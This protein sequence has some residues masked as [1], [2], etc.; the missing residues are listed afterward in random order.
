[1]TSTRMSSPQPREHLTIII[2][3]SVLLNIGC[4]QIF[5]TAASM[6]LCFLTMDVFFQEFFALRE[7]LYHWFFVI[8]LLVSYSSAQEGKSNF[9]PFEDRSICKIW[10]RMHQRWL[11]LFCVQGVCSGGTFFFF[12]LNT[13]VMGLSSVE[14]E[15]R[16]L[17]S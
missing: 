8:L 5:K 2:N 12:T 17:L 3:F 9:S 16:S 4:D 14:C 1:M 13:N 11:N 7:R 15:R 6:I 10:K